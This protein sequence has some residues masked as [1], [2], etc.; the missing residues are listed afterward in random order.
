MAGLS[1]FQQTRSTVILLQETR[2]ISILI[3]FFC[4]SQVIRIIKLSQFVIAI[5]FDRRNFKNLAE[6]TYHFRAICFCLLCVV[7]IFILTIVL[8]LLLT[9]LIV[10]RVVAVRLIEYLALSVLVIFLL[11][12]LFCGDETIFAICS[13]SS[14]IRLIFCFL[15]SRV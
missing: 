14:F 7:F 11:V 6:F 12:F 5:I 1:Y 9:V 13:H 3:W 4:C 15:T 10:F 8:N 2:I